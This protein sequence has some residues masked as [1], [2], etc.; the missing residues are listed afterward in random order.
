MYKRQ[1]ADAL[2]GL[3]VPAD[4]Q[5]HYLA[6]ARPCCTIIDSYPPAQRRA[7]DA[8]LDRLIAQRVEAGLDQ[9]ALARVRD[10][11]LEVMKPSGDQSG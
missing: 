10:I 5:R 2:P 7:M 8:G 4:R 3:N 1:V 11:C 6:F 9:E